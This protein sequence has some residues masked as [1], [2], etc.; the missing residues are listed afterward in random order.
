MSA[1]HPPPVPDAQ[2]EAIVAALDGRAIVLVGMMGAGKS[3]IGRR[4]SNLLQLPFFDTDKQIEQAQGQSISEIFAEKGEEAFRKSETTVLLELT[5][6]GSV[7]IAAGGGA[8]VHATPRHAL[9]TSPAL[10]LWLKVSAQT[11]YLRV[12]NSNQ[13]PLL[14]GAGLRTKIDKLVAE[15]DQLY[16]SADLAIDN[17]GKQPWVT[18]QAAI[19]ALHGHLVSDP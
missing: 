7:V 10:T 6:R 3:Q 1:P 12:K 16:L 18:C 19:A 14:A 9:L 4:L 2:R 15:R 17:N 11:I 8:F 13:R 5:A